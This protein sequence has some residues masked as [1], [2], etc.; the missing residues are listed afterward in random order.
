MEVS[1]C[2]NQRTSALEKPVGGRK[3]Q[4]APQQDWPFSVS[5]FGPAALNQGM[6]VPVC[7]AFSG[8]GGAMNQSRLSQQGLWGKQTKPHEDALIPE[9]SLR[10]QLASVNSLCESQ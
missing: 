1:S 6:E 7:P 9:R 2:K 10:S 3:G 8:E 5:F 4:V